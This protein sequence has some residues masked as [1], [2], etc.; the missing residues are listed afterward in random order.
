MT[1]SLCKY[2]SAGADRCLLHKHL[3]RCT[4]GVADDVD[5]LLSLTDAA[6]LQVEEKNRSILRVVSLRYADV[7]RHL[8]ITDV[9]HCL[10]VAR[11][12]FV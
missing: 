6:A 2:V 1:L 3:L 11:I 12:G 10:F 4:V 7:C 8:Q 9:R 5:A